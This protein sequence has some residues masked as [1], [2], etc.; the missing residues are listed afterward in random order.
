[1]D[2]IKEVLPK[3]NPTKPKSWI[4]TELVDGPDILIATQIINETTIIVYAAQYFSAALKYYYLRID[5][6]SYIINPDGVIID[7]SIGAVQGCSN[8]GHV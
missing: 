7:D 6:D 8:C 4:R 3:S 5:T 2:K 1:M